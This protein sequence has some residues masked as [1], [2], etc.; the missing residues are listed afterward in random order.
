MG[1]FDWFN[2]PLDISGA[3][4]GINNLGLIG[5]TLRDVGSSLNGQQ[6]S[7]LDSYYTRA[8]KANNWAESPPGGDV[9]ASDINN[10]GLIGATLRDAGASLNGQQSSALEAFYTRAQKMNAQRRGAGRTTD[11]S[12]R[13]TFPTYG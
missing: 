8:Q 5:A 2:A 1:L 3:S 13:S 12:Y 7:A 11:A 4:D 6:S 9:R 10:L